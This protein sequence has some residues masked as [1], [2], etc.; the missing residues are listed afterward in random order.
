MNHSPMAIFDIFKA[1][2]RNYV[3]Y[4][5]KVLKEFIFFREHNEK[6]RVNWPTH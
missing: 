4:L 5:L 1:C 2:R 6:V 3:A